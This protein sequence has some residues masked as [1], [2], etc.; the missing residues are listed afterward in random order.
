MSGIPVRRISSEGN[1]QKVSPSGGGAISAIDG[2]G[3]Y[4]VLFATCTDYAKPMTAP[5]TAPTTADAKEMYNDSTG[6]KLVSLDQVEAI[7]AG[8]CIA[9]CWSYTEDDDAYVQ[10]QIAAFITEWATPAGNKYSNVIW[11]TADR[12]YAE[13]LWDEV[14][15]VKTF[16]IMTSHSAA[17]DVLA[18]VG[19]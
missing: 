14:N 2:D 19:E 5:L 1:E 17:L 8:E 15:R 6:A 12:P 11:I 4:G 18:T 7:P 9:L 10:A 13:K 16:G 3:N